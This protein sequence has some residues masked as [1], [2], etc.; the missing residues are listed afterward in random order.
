[1][2]MPASTIF[3]MVSVATPRKLTTRI[4][5]FLILSLHQNR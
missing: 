2:P 3:L 4:V 1:L 5:A